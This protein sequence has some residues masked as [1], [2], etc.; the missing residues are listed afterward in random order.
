LGIVLLAGALW[1][2]V[3]QNGSQ[4]ADGRSL[5]VMPFTVLGAAPFP[6][7]QLPEYFLSRFSPVPRLP[8]AL[9]FR[10]VRERAGSEPLSIVEADSVAGQL[11]ARYFVN[12]SIVFAAS[13][14]TLNADL[15]QTGSSDP[16]VSA[17]QRGSVDS[18]SAVM[19]AAWAEILGEGFQPNRY[20]TIPSGKEAIAAFLNG[21]DAFRRGDYDHARELY[22]VVIARDPDFAPAYL[23]RMLAIA[24]VAPEEDMLAEGAGARQRRA[25]HARGQ[26]VARGYGAPGARHD[27]RA[28]RF[29]PGAAA[30]PT[31]STASRWGSSTFLRQL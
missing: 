30:R 17:S 12:A 18:M 6:S 28:E 1:F 14:V 16:V 7:E 10:R 27:C 3:G 25:A 22:D 11:G 24:Q 5:A 20:A 31:P 26:P 8:T 9:S 2:V 23:H 21:D 19:D 13:G 15:Y 29:R 4:P